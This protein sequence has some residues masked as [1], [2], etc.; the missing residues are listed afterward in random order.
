MVAVVIGL[1]FVAAAGWGGYALYRHYSPTEQAMAELRTTPLVGSVM[2][3]HPE[4]EKELRAAIR[5]EERHPTTDGPSRPAIIMGD[6]RQE[7]IASGV[8]SADD[9]SLLAAMA[10]RVELVRHL[11][12]V[13][14]SACHEFATSGIQRPEKLDAEGQRLYRNVL[15]A[16]EAAYRS[17]HGAKALPLPNRTEVN[18]MMRQ[19]GFTKHDFDM[20]TNFGALSNDTSCEIELK[21]DSVPPLLPPDK[22]ALF[23]RFI[24]AQ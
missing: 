7:Y 18:E 11:M 1:A 8:R 9:A 10:A 22:R 14:T 19:A 16:M 23:A 21:I 2:A 3:E 17:G 4:V 15:A 12:Q 13:D 6:L 20:V 5:E 24:L